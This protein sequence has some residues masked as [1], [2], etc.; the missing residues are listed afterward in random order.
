MIWNA[1]FKRDIDVGP[2]LD[3]TIIIRLG[4]TCL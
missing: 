3:S 2:I 4:G 1:I